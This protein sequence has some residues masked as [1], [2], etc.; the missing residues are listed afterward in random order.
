[1]ITL[2]PDRL[3]LPLA[4]PIL[5][6]PG[7]W[8]A[9]GTLPTAALGA[10]LTAPLGEPWDG[11]A[12]A[13]QALPGALRWRPAV[14]PLERTLARL[15]RHRSELPLILTL[16]PDEPAAISAALDSVALDEMAACLL[17]EATPKTVRAARRVVGPLPIIA[18]WPCNSPAPAEAL[19]TAGADLLW[20]GPPR[21]SDGMRLWGPALRPLI[22]DGL[23]RLLPLGLPLVAGAAI[24]SP[25]DALALRDAGAALFALGPPW[26]VEP[27][28]AAAVGVALRG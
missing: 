14:R 24:A 4:S 27:S 23:Q 1:M 19:A 13:W 3:P 22:R 18:E 7:L 11:N 16:A 2:T 9:R 15:R 12:M 21:L 25:D 6:S 26:W 10:R 28:L 17:W 8:A 20:V 5:P